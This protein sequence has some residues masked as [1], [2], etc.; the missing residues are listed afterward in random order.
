MQCPVCN[1]DLRR[2]D[3]GEHGFVVL[4]VCE[5][6][7]GAW[8]DNT[9]VDRLDDSVWTNVEEHEFH[10]VAGD[11]PNANCPKCESALTSVSP[12]DEPDLIIDRCLACGGFW[13][14]S[15]ELDR[16]RNLA[17]SVDSKLYEKITHISKP[18]DWSWIRWEVYLFRQRFGAGD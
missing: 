13:L 5:K 4:D 11:H 17:S 10:V 9:E 2:T 8:F 3:L 12:P 1:V 6:C 18:L 7:N 16:M 14:D 15:G